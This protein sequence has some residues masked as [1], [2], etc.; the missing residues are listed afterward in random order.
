MTEEHEQKYGRQAA[1]ESIHG[2]PGPNNIV[3]PYA[4]II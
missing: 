2:I 1:A 4:Y 3:D